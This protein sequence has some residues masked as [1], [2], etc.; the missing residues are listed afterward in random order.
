MSTSTSNLTLMSADLDVLKFDC[1]LHDRIVDFYFGYLS[2]KFTTEDILLVPPTVTTCLLSCTPHDHETLKSFLSQL[3]LTKRQL[4]LFALNNT[5]VIGSKDE[6]DAYIDEG[7]HW[8][9]VVF[10]RAGMQF[11]HHDSKEGQNEQHAVKLYETLKDQVVPAACSSTTSKHN[12]KKKKKGGGLVTARTADA[13][14]AVSFCTGY[15]PQ[16]SNS[17]DCGLYLL[18]VAKAIC[19]WHMNERRGER[20]NW[21]AAVK[22]RVKDSYVETNMRRDILHLAQ[23]Y[24]RG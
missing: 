9:L 13:S 16:Q 15:T 4:V 23:K 10:N 20:D 17:F 12:I 5:D 22:E 3:Q 2:S 19:E 11:V 7:D 14:S 18:A 24:V 8:S 21:F 6:D 1:Y